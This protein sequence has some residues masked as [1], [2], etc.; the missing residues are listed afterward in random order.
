MTALKSTKS[1]TAL[2]RILALPIMVGALS[3]C[4][5]ASKLPDAPGSIGGYELAKKPPS[6]TGPGEA[7]RLPPPPAETF[8]KLK[9]PVADTTTEVVRDTKVA[10][11]PKPLADGL[12][13]TGN[14]P[15]VPA[16]APSAD[17]PLEQVAFSPLDFEAP[18]LSAPLATVPQTAAPQF[19]VPQAPVAQVA[20]SDYQIP[21]AP[22]DGL[23]E[24]LNAPIPAPIEVATPDYQ[25]IAQ[26]P[27]QS[28]PEAVDIG[29]Q[30]YTS[31]SYDAPSYST[32][33]DAITQ[34]YETTALDTYAIT[35]T[36]SQPEVI[37]YESA[38][39]QS[40]DRYL[41]TPVEA[42]AIGAAPTVPL[43]TVSTRIAAPLSPIA[44]RRVRL[45]NGAVVNVHPVIGAPGTA[46]ATLADTVVATIGT[47]VDES[48]AQNA[49]VS[50][51][52]RGRAE[53]NTDGYVSVEWQLLD[54]N[55][56]VVGIFPERQ[57]GAG[58]R[59]MSDSS[60]QAMGQRVADRIARNGEL[61]QSTLYAAANPVNETITETFATAQPVRN[62]VFT[63]EKG[64]SL[65]SAPMP[66]RSPRA[67]TANVAP[68]Q[69]AQVAP[70]PAPVTITP[71]SR[72]AVIPP[73]PRPRI[74]TQAPSPLVE[75]API[76]LIPEAP[77][78]VTQAPRPV[79]PPPSFDTLRPS[80][81]TQP[82]AAPTV[83]A[84]GP[85]PLVFRGVQG[86]PGDG[87]QALG[88]EVGKLL[89]QS[90]AQMTTTA[91]PGALIL[92]AQVSKTQGANGD[93]I[94]I[95]WRVQDTN[96]ENVGQVT[97]AN[98]VPRGLLDNAWG[99]DAVY[100]AEGARD[101]IIE[102]LQGVGALDS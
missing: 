77:Q 42:Y 21:A 33:V 91:Q 39:V 20:Q 59:Q 99:E 35:G 67:R 80:N 29:T 69:V 46:S 36:T 47:P 57:N 43:E 96:G 66:R 13:N 89:A 94:E 8:A 85:R 7:T 6:V 10:L 83:V 92:S 28:F 1:S 101:G 90:G 61:R 30:S 19:S 55:K 48:T 37:S 53:R 3:A 38:P 2:A 5:Y 62:S 4:D 88:R 26:A 27:S 64:A 95:I 18:Q 63:L 87:D 81:N 58:W 78:V 49:A 93:R 86:A 71:P 16:P 54:T 100:A 15:A 34:S 102:L 84:T 76:Q 82:V 97:Q 60:L 31:T 73:A 11:L 52:L 45:P 14:F 9:A 41:S 74:V 32:P 56:A 50:Y 51:D 40:V 23:A 79:A 25:A 70:R 68:T 22:L 75:P 98:E 17:T 44:V 24:A 65:A 72:P 12:Q